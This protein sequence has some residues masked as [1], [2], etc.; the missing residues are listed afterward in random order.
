M[1][2]SL[3]EKKWAGLRQRLGDW[4]RSARRN[5]PWRRTTDPYAITV[6]EFM[7]QQTQ[8]VTVIPYYERWL[9]QFPTWDAL[10]GAKEGAVIKAWEGL[11]YYRRA[12]SLQALAKT[13]VEQGGEL[14]RSEEGLLALPGIGPYTAAAVGSIAL[15]LPLAVLDGNVM[16]VLTRVLA[17]N[18][19]IARAPTRA[20]LQRIANAFLDKDDPS[21]HNQA[22]MELGATVC[23]PRNPMC[24][25]CPLKSG[26]IGKTRA[27]E[28]PVK[29]RTAT[30]KRIETVA[31]LRHGSRY[32]CEQVPAGKPWHG[33]WRFPDFD[34]ARMQK[35]EP[36]AKIRYSITKYAVIMEAV[37]AKWKRR[38]PV[39]SSVRYLTPVEMQELAFAAPHR[40]LIK[41]L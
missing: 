27:E 38:A 16:R 28:F 22:V 2:S 25:I 40:K 11:G 18:D 9:K 35:G 36:I 23:L 1:K 15:G 4:Y 6:S 3:P 14:P 5:L 34:P 19:D 30:E 32:Y 24:L 26:C 13:V 39:S 17:M 31:V 41:F 10:A 29:S 20:K 37:E 8:V 33:L 12:R 7:L 21:T